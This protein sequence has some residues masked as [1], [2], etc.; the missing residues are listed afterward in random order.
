[1]PAASLFQQAMG[2]G[3]TALAPALQRFHSLAGRHLLHGEAT[4]QAAQGPLAR[5]LARCV[6]APLNDATGAILFELDAAPQ[7]E[8]WTRHFPG[9]T[10]RSRLHLEGRAVVERLGPARLAFAVYEVG[11]GLQMRLVH[12][13][14]L[15]IPCPA[16]L[17]P[18]LVAHETGA[19]GRLHF[20]I[21]A[22]LPGI[23][24]MVG[25]RGWLALPEQGGGA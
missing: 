3:F 18:R 16:W 13:H 2:D 8:R 23:G 12:M 4:T 22:A 10:M 24:R 25:Y 19:A 7:T 21:E 5:L 15:G 17:R 11:G 14:F 1:M 20:H 6:G 9:H